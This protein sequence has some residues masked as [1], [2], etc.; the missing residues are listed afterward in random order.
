MPQAPEEEIKKLS[1]R[2]KQVRK[3]RKMTQAD[4][5]DVLNISDGHYRKI[6][7]GMMNPG[8][9]SLVKLCAALEISIEDFFKGFK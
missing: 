8:Y 9:L 4:V 6:E 1:K 5:A 2:I 3:E 7:N